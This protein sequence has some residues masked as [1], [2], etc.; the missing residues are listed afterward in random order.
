[1]DDDGLG[2]D[3]GRS[4]PEGRGGT[5]NFDLDSTLLS[6][7]RRDVRWAPQG[8]SDVD[9]AHRA[10]RETWALGPRAQSLLVGRGKGRGRGTGETRKA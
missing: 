2:R 9:V 3:G 6:K 10:H 7:D 5:G 4:E 8:P 1:M